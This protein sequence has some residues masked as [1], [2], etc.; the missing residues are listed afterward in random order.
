MRHLVLFLYF[1]FLSSGF[2]GIT[3][4]SILWKRLGHRFLGWI[5]ALVSTFTAWLLVTAI[6][7]YLEQIIRIP[8]ARF[9][10]PVNLL[11]GTLAYLFLLFSMLSSPAPVRKPELLLALSPMLLY[12]LL[13]LLGFT[14]VPGIFVFAEKH[15][16]PFMF[17]NLAAGSIF[18]FYIG[19]GFLE[20]ARRLKQDTAAFI[21][22][23]YGFALLAFGIAILVFSLIL[24]LLGTQ[25]EQV[26]LLEFFFFF[27]LNMLTL[28]AFIRY[29]RQPNAF[30]EDGKISRQFIKEYGI[31]RREAEVIEMVSRGMSNREIA[32]NLF[33]SFPTVRTHVYN[34]FKKTGASS[35]LEL[36]RI[37]SR[38][39]Q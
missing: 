36:L 27:F 32:E 23:G 30:I 19:R 14:L 24:A 25:V 34:I 20:A 28:A 8:A 26:V 9:L 4:I 33:V 31:S 10:G 12:Y 29:I 7:Y 39:R 21:L 37:A 16:L 6:V 3:M 17:F 5:L 13:L 1:I 11:M 38:Y 35:R 22:R 15:P 18:V 2:A